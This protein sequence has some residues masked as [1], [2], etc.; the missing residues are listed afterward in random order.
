LNIRNIQL[1][2][3][4]L[5]YFLFLVAIDCKSLDL[6]L[7]AALFLREF[8]LTVLCDLLSYGG[9]FFELF[10]KLVKSRDRVTCLPLASAATRAA[11]S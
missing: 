11:A 5:N 2:V 1:V 3:Q 9:M 10:T 4:L 7:E 8:T 6:S